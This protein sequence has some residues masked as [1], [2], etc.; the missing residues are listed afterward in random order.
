MMGLFNKLLSNFMNKF[1]EEHGDELMTAMYKVNNGGDIP[2][3]QVQQRLNIKIQW[4]WD[5]RE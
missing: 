5:K 4:N 2:V 3:D 1:V